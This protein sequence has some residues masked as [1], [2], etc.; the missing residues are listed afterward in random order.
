MPTTICSLK[1]NVFALWEVVVDPRWVAPLPV[2]VAVVPSKR[3]WKP[4]NN[5][6]A[7]WA[8]VDLPWAVFLPASVAVKMCFSLRFYFQF[9][10]SLTLNLRLGN[11]SNKMNTIFSRKLLFII[12]LTRLIRHFKAKFK[13]WHNFELNFA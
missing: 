13:F 10:K 12:P 5:V 6:F 7:P 1:S 9:Y 11:F 8:A 2:S 4:R 3:R